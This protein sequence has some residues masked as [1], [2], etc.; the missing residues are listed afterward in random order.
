MLLLKV[1]VKKIYWESL[2][3]KLKTKELTMN[4]AND[5]ISL[6]FNRIMKRTKC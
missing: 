5:L 6:A 2:L 1:E 4:C 3:R